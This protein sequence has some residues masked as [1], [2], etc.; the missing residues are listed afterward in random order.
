MNG[1]KVTKLTNEDK[2]SVVVQW[3]CWN[4]YFVSPSSN[5]MAHLFLLSGNQGAAAVL[6]STGL[7][8]I[9]SDV[10]LSSLL[11][12][13]LLVPG[14]TIGDAMQEAKR[15]LATGEYLVDVMLG[16]TLMGDPTLVVDEIAD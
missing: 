9:T 11:T 7:T 16:W 15:E 3:G 6:G 14:K 10:A 2:P 1:T 5:G 13:K 8:S 12:P 4:T